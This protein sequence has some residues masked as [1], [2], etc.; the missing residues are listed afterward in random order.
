MTTG[1]RIQQARKQ[2]GLSQRE[3]GEKLGV[4]GSMIGQYENDLRNPKPK[5]IFKIATALGVMPYT[6]Y[7]ESKIVQESC[8]LADNVGAAFGLLDGIRKE[9]DTPWLIK[10][11]IE[12]TFP[13]LAEIIEQLPDQVESVIYSAIDD[14]LNESRLDRIRIALFRLNEEGQEKAAERVEE[15]TEIPKYQCKNLDKK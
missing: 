6:L 7:G 15:L 5:T 14:K 9:E 13:N 4:S 10:K 8:D 1:K 12:D 11:A 3:L 2:A